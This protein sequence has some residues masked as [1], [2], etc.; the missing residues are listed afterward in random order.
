[1]KKALFV[2]FTVCLFSACSG[3][4]PEMQSYTSFIIKLDAETTIFK[5]TKTAYFNEKGECVLI[6]EHGNLKP[7]INT[8]EF[9][10]TE[11]HD[12]IYIFYEWENGSRLKAAFIPKKNTK[13]I[14]S[15]SEKNGLGI[16]IEEKTI[17]NWPH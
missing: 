2:L 9:I 4:D 12:S 13:N 8:D 17:Y 11:F 7:Y 16:V 14:F 3:D 6:A 10:M 1:M 5:N 15:I